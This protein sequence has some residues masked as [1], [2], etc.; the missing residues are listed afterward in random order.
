MFGICYDE[1]AD[2]YDFN[3]KTY[4]MEFKHAVDEYV[5][6]NRPRNTCHGPYAACVLHCVGSTLII[7]YAQSSIMKKLRITR[8]SPAYWRV[9]FDNP[10]LNLI[11]P[12]VLHELRDLINQFEAADELKVVVFD[13][14]NPEFYIAHVDFLRVGETAT[15]VT[16][17]GLRILPDF[18]Q[19]LS[20]LPIITIASIRGR[21]R[22]IGVEFVEG[23]DIRFGSRENMI[24]GQI[25]VGAALIPGAGGSVYLP[26]LVGRARAFEIIASSEDFD[27]DTA[28][29]YGWINRAIPDAELDDFVD[30]FARRVASFEKKALT[31]A[32]R[33]VNRSSRLPDDDRFAAAYETFMRM[34]TWPETRSRIAKIVELGLQKPGD[35][36]LRLGHHLGV[37]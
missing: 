34:L 10:P 2:H 7:K 22:G 29:R 28:E 26:L 12:D 21:A 27:A 11:D 14:A 37:E 20:R 9:T 8:Q 32:K 1:I 35:F 5:Q 15:D 3:I 33:L 31:E 18:M 4:F 36:E 23:L 13:S 17:T 6:Q 25:E 24:L 19:R 30:R 16:P